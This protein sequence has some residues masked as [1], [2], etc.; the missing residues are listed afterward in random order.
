MLN[1]DDLLNLLN[2]YCPPP[3]PPAKDNPVCVDECFKQLIISSFKANSYKLKI[4]IH[5]L[6]KLHVMAALSTS[7][8]D[9]TN[10]ETEGH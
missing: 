7:T 10:W 5:T 2:S 9:I 4:P 1:R 8:K 3:P 6:W